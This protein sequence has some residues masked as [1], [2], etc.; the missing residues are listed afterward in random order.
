[1]L[2]ATSMD[3]Q[4]WPFAM[5]LA[6]ILLPACELLADS[7]PGDLANRV[8]RLLVEEVFSVAQ[9]QFKLAPRCDDPTYLRRIF[10][11][12]VGTVPTPKEVMDF[13]LDLSL[14]HI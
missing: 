13:S 11:D 9:G 10:L 8:D 7:S 12:L 3:R 2:L 5:L 1:M 14:I 6:V 4:S